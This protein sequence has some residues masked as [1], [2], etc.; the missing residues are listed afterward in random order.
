MSDA[1]QLARWWWAVSQQPREEPE[2]VR[3]VP[4]SELFG[5]PVEAYAEGLRADERREVFPRLGWRPCMN[6]GESR[7][8]VSE[9][10]GWCSRCER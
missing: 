7:P 4:L 2:P 3:M 8:E 9:N 1:D 5:S 6:C 10:G